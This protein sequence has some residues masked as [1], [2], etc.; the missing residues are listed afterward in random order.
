[1]RRI[2]Q[3]SGTNRNSFYYHYVDIEDLARTA[4]RN[5]AEG[6]RGL[7]AWLLSAFQTG[8]G[9]TPMPDAS[10]VI[11]AGRVM[12]CARSAS[13]FLR[14]MVKDLL[15]ETWFDAFGIDASRLTPEELVQVEFI[16]AGLVAVLGGSEIEKSPLVMISFA[17]SDI[18]KASIGTLEGIAAAQMAPQSQG[19]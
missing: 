7:M 18:G 2:S 11:H 14:G 5:N 15:C 3:E 10:I 1:M 4:F 17:L 12:L 8:S 9:S 19:A 13:P 6:A 16:L